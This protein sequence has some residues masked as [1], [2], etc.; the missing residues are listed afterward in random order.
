[1]SVVLCVCVCVRARVCAGLWL[2]TSNIVLL[3]MFIAI[4]SE[5]YRKVGEEV[6]LVYM[7]VPTCARLRARAQRTYAPKRET[8][9]FI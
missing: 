7:D 1:M 3:N 5:A 8:L 6:Q 4:L 2:I 9:R